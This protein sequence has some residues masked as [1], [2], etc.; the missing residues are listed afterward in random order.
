MKRIMDQITEFCFF[1]SGEPVP[2][3][4]FR[5]GGRNGG[6]ADPRVKAWQ[7][8]VG[9]EAQCARLL[10]RDVDDPTKITMIEGAVS[11]EL[12]FSLVDRRR[13][14]LDNLSKGVL[15]GL[16]GVLF[17]DDSQV[18][19]LRLR[20]YVINNDPRAPI[21]AKPGVLIKVR[22]VKREDAF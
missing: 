19:V 18:V 2:K 9:W 15:D 21:Q 20:K 7:E 12:D 4:S 11:V 6:H 10:A 5:A 3:Q 22:P 8:L 17:K 16:K 1:V 14:D 13:V